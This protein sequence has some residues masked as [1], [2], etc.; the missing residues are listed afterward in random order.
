MLIP[1]TKLAFPMQNPTRKPV[2]SGVISGYNSIKIKEKNFF[3]LPFILQNHIGISHPIR[4]GKLSGK[5]KITEEIRI[6]E[7]EIR[8]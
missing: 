8:K 1:T 2:F 7:K 4:T 3:S 6:T 5:N